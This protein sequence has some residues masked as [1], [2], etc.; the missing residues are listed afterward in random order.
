MPPN[1]HACVSCTLRNIKYVRAL[2]TFSFGRVEGEKKRGNGKM[3]AGGTGAQIANRGFVIRLIR[4]ITEIITSVI[5]EQLITLPDLCRMGRRPQMSTT[6]PFRYRSVSFRPVRCFSS[7]QERREPPVAAHAISSFL[8][9]Q[10]CSRANSLYSVHLLYFR[11]DGPLPCYYARTSL[12]YLT[13]TRQQLPSSVESITS[14]AT[15]PANC[16]EPPSDLKK[17]PKRV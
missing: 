16:H 10:Q 5:S 4:G 2:P 3:G 12:P 13:P 1:Q 6:P 17:S 7:E 11:P 8:I 14:K 15:K 9:D